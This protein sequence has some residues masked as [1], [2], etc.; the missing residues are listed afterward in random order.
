M[1][2]EYLKHIKFRDQFKPESSMKDYF[3]QSPH[4]RSQE[5]EIDYEQQEEDFERRKK[6]VIDFLSR[7]LND[8]IPSL[9]LSGISFPINYS[10]WNEK[11]N[12]YLEYYMNEFGILG[13]KHFVNHSDCEGYL[14]YG[15]CID[16]MNLFS[17]IFIFK[18]KFMNEEDENVF[19]EDL[20]DLF[21]TSVENKSYVV[22]G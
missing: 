17:R 21:K 6:N 11:K 15:E 2:I 7:T 5:E 1:T 9:G 14:S 12:F 10:V 3:S 8:K 13:L 22:F 18:D 4:D 20:V 16:I 19:F